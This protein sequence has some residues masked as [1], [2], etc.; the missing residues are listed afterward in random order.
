[1]REHIENGIALWQS[2]NSACSIKPSVD[3]TNGKSQCDLMVGNIIAKVKKERNEVEVEQKHNIFPEIQNVLEK[4]DRFNFEISSTKENKSEVGRVLKIH[5]RKEDTEAVENWKKI[6]MCINSDRKVRNVM[7]VRKVYLVPKY[8]CT[9]Y[10][11]CD[12]I[13]VSKKLLRKHNIL[14]HCECIRSS[15][16]DRNEFKNYQC[17]KCDKTAFRPQEQILYEVR[18]IP[19][20]MQTLPSRICK[21]QHLRSAQSKGTPKYRMFCL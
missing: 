5:I 17:D 16:T 18:R 7:N 10:L 12:K 6:K 8:K 3:A 13:F 4:H 20:Q 2:S 9:Y 15:T 11:Q 14:M 1:M 21:L 19:L